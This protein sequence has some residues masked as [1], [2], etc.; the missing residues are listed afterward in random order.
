MHADIVE[1]V[2]KI[3]SAM[4]DLSSIIYFKDTHKESV[5]PGSLET[6]E[7]KWVSGQAVE[8]KTR[9]EHLEAMLAGSQE[10]LKASVLQREQDLMKRTRD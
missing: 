8:L 7:G 1:T 5:A 3:Q 9:S 6:D 4:D 2:E 10:A